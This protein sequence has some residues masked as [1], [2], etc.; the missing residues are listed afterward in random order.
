M[1]TPDYL[2]HVTDDIVAIYSELE[3]SIIQDVARR[4]IKTDFATD[5]AS[6]QM[7]KLQQAGIVY[8]D[9]LKEISKITGKSEAELKRM[10][11]DSALETLAFDDE[12]YKKAGLSP[13]PLKQSPAMLNILTAGLQKTDGILKNLTLTTA[14]TSQVAYI[15]A[16]DLAYMQVASGAFDYN[17]AIRNAIRQ[18]SKEGVSILYPTGHKDKVDVASRRATLTGVS[19]TCGQLQIQ[20]MDDMD[21]DLVETTAHMGARLEHS[22]WQGRVFSRSGRH[23]T[24]P[25]FVSSTGYGT[26]AG[27]MGWNCRHNFYPFFDGLSQRNY[28]DFELKELSERKVTYNDTEYSDY[29]ASQ[30]QRKLEREIRATKR[31]LVGLDAGVK[32][33]DKEDLKKALQAD[34]T[35]A[36]V[37]LKSQE[38]K[39]RDFLEQ[40]KR[41]EENARTQVQGFGRSQAQKAVQAHKKTLLPNF[42]NAEIPDSKIVGYALNKNHPVGKNKAIAFE[43]YLG[44][45]VDNK[46]DLVKEI[47]KGLKLY[48]AKERK[49]TQYGKPFEVRMKIKGANGKRARVKTGWII[50]NSNNT[51]RLTSVYVDE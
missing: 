50:D 28:T 4:I 7:E 16:C 15:Q 6:W 5:T 10:F 47:Q 37:K 12:V 48:S 1:L 23:K 21:C 14:N 2:Q 29:D 46:D 30:I 49:E 27:L 43:K 26:G 40:T 39:M 20:R 35:E 32:A 31:E 19:Q 18:A 3:D 44:Y 13:L 22:F 9:A 25:D 24:Y 33:T 51:P 8:E 17:T 38:A 45:N 11:Q 36:S 34:F 41:F 42:K